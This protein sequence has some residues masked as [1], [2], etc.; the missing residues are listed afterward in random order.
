MLFKSKSTHSKVHRAE[1]KAVPRWHVSIR[2]ESDLLQTGL[3]IVVDD[4]WVR[5]F[6]KQ[7]THAFVVAT[8]NM[9]KQYTGSLFA[10]QTGRR[11]TK[12]HSCGIWCKLVC[13]YRVIQQNLPLVARPSAV[14]P[15]GPGISWSMDIGKSDTRHCQRLWCY[16]RDMPQYE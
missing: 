4:I 1:V 14:L 3:A 13:R 9:S 12:N 7:H 10:G 11:Y 8:C 15:K 6:C 5:T 2:C 16:C